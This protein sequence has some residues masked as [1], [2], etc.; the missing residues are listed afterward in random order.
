[1]ACLVPAISQ[2]SRA[3]AQEHVFVYHFVPVRPL[4]DCLIL[5]VRKQPDLGNGSESDW[6]TI[7]SAN[8]SLLDCMVT[9]MH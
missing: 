3:C 4:N 7:Q 2:K 6:C 8:L 1:M 9:N 5:F